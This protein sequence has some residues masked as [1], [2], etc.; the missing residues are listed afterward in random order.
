MI[1]KNDKTS[2]VADTEETMNAPPEAG[3][4]YKADAV[5][6]QGADPAEVSAAQDGK[7]PTSKA[8]RVT[9]IVFLSLGLAVVVFLFTVAVTLAVDK[10]VKKK[11][12]PAFCGISTLIVQT[13]SMSGTIDEG[14]LIIVKRRDDYRVGDIIT[15]MPEYAS[16][17]TTHRIVRIQDGKFYTKGDANNAEDTRPIT[18]DNIVGK[19]VGTV[20]HVGLF[21]RWIKDD[22]GWAYIVAVAAVVVSGVIFYKVFAAKKEN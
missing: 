1:R 9:G 3:A 13:G 17:P 4:E 19:V 18:K 2:A 14:D 11:P 8:K 15:F 20:P 10:F 16:V 6:E 5:A 22:F 7:K 21:F 12:V